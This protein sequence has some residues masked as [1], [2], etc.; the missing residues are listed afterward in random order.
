MR[1]SV[2]PPILLSVQNS[3]LDTLTPATAMD[4]V[5]SDPASGQCGREG[6]SLH[7]TL[8]HEGAEGD[9]V[10]VRGSYHLY[11]WNETG[12][13]FDNYTGGRCLGEER[14]THG[15]VL[16]SPTEFQSVHFGA[17]MLAKSLA[18]GVA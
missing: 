9:M 6:S 1:K 3:G 13:D 8:E 4:G 2:N 17:E 12:W 15:I 14:T 11:I 7:Y 5:G 18:V 10:V 16:V